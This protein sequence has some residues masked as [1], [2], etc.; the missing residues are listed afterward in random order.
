VSLSKLGFGLWNV[1]ALEMPLEVAL[2]V[3]GFLF[4]LSSTRPRGAWGRRFPWIALVVLLGLQSINW[5]APPPTGGAAF[6]GLGLA[7]YAACVAL[8]WGLDRTR[9]PRARLPSPLAA[10]VRLLQLDDALLAATG[11]LDP[12]VLRSLDA[13]HVASALALGE[14]LEELVTYD[15]RMVDA[16]RLL[17]MTARAPGAD[18]ERPP[19]RRR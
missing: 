5:F 14:D 6:S 17:G 9:E 1:P 7:A 8:G 11:D 3:N 15:R 10:R 16:A 12:R 18:W 4:Y 13:I 19:R 2:V